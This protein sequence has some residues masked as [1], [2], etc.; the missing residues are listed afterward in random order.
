M[1]VVEGSRVLAR[2]FEAVVWDGVMRP[3]KEDFQCPTSVTSQDV[4]QLPHE[5]VTSVTT[6]RSENPELPSRRM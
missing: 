3:L 2:L 1:S 4:Y 5:A 6:D